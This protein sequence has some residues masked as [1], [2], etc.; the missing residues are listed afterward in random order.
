MRLLLFNPESDLALAANDP[1][2]TP[3]ASARRMAE[4]L[5]SLPSLWAGSGDVILLPDNS[6][7]SCMPPYQ[8]GSISIADCTSVLPWG[9]N[10]LI[11]HR[12]RQARVPTSLLPSDT[13]LD[14][15]RQLASRATAAKVLSTLITSP[16]LA[17]WR[18]HLVGEAIPCQTLDEASAAHASFGTALFKQP[19][20]GSGR[21]LHPATTA[22]ISPK[23]EAWL[24]R[25]I[26]NQG[27]VMAEPIYNKVQDLA[28][29]FWAHPDGSVTFE[30]LSIF[31]TTPGGVYNGNLVASEEMKRAIIARHIPIALLDDVITFLRKHLEL[32]ITSHLPYTGPIGVDMML[33]NS[34]LNSKPS[35]LT[36]SLHPCVEIN[37]RM[38]MGMVALYISRR[39][40]QEELRIFNI[41]CRDGHYEAILEQ[42]HKKTPL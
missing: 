17:R 34:A 18:M 28:A 2:Y 6:L 15:Y 24:Q 33:V 30:G 26:R 22:T 39:E 14:A 12:L 7:V 41:V 1:H 36:Y 21:G 9:W 40:L 42:M 16:Q 8:G 35:T 5:K 31:L 38:T 4:D 29:E 37:W 25:T 32:L 19:W 27:F 23:T 13:W 3:P 20:S 11:A 10:L